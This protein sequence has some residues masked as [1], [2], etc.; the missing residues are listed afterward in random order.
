MEKF[1]FMHIYAQNPL[2]ILSAYIIKQFSV[3]N[4]CEFAC[5]SAKVRKAALSPEMCL[6][7]LTLRT[8]A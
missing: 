1:L 7:F 6:H 2:T 3:P 5:L 8:L 4:K